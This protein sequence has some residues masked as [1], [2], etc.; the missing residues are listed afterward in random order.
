REL[1]GDL[2]AAE[3]HDIRPGG[4]GREPAE[5]LQLAQYQP[6]GVVRQQPGE[7]VDARVL[8]V[9]RTERVVDVCV[10]ER[11]E[12]GGEVRPRRLVL[13]G[14]PRVEPQVLQQRDAAG[15]ETVHSGLCGGTHRVGGERDRRGKQFAE[16]SRHRRPA[17]LRL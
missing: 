5:Y 3:Y 17:V 13:A 2:G 6:A 11:G 16:A 10:A 4:F 15:R 8:A 1:V 9:Y 7:F 14:L 12:A